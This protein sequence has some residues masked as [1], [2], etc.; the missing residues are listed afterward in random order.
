MSNG[1][2]KRGDLSSFWDVFLKVYDLCKE[3][4]KIFWLIIAFILSFLASS[5]EAISLGLIIPLLNSVI[6][7]SRNAELGILNDLVNMFSIGETNNL[8]IVVALMI[9][10]AVILKN[11]FTYIAEWVKSHIVSKVNLS[12][13][14]KLMNKF[15][16]RDTLFFEK[17]SIGDLNFTLGLSSSFGNI[18]SGFH[19][20]L[21]N[22]FFC[23]SYAAVMVFISP[24]ITVFIILTF[25]PS[26]Y[27]LKLLSKIIKKLSQK[28]IKLNSKISRYT[29][30]ILSSIRLIKLYNTEEKED[31]KFKDLNEK[32]RKLNFT[33]GLK[34]SLAGKIQEPL[35]VAS[36]ILLAGISFFFFLDNTK[37]GIAG[38]MAF[39]VILKRFEFPAQ[40]LIKE[41]TMLPTKTPSLEKL[42]S[43]FKEEPWM[44]IK[45]GNKEFK[46][47][48]K[49][50]QFKNVSFKYI[51]D[52]ETV[53]KNINLKI[54]K[55][56]MT[57]LVGSTGAGKST[58]ANLIPRI[59]DCKK[60]KIIIDGINVR[61]Y[62]INSLRK[63]IAFVSQDSEI[64]NTTIRDNIC[65]GIERKVTNKELKSVIKKTALEDFVK[66]LP[67]KLNT[68][69]GE[70]GIDVS[71][72][73]KQRISIA[74][75]LIKDPD[76][77]ILDEATSA[78]DT[79]TERK[80]QR[81]IEHALKGRTV[82][83]I[84]HRLST[85]EKA[86]KIVVIEKGKI[87]E[88]GSFK[89][90]LKKKRMFYHYW[91]IQTKL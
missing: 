89:Q 71:G 78:L 9:L 23:I 21:Q 55:G 42:I 43:G 3:Q 46:N 66:K 47:L 58:I 41:I 82:L 19:G 81:S 4:V 72:G 12:L 51:K 27:F 76:I 34:R 87:I 49:E 6:D 44:I 85:I 18:I 90:L 48:K 14:T 86:D 73:E 77:L 20:I 24:K 57:A 32:S 62:D 50:I 7:P 39:F 54:K 26:Y 80:I 68:I 5:L 56:E 31:E 17:S 25:L 69:L 8:I 16:K 37:G 83:A 15:L 1:K 59:F 88:Q 28:S 33:I 64:L 79:V 2:I 10:L 40:D 29:F 13:K 35:L 70:R 30:E 36:V 61:D 22:L 63:N 67:K 60:G 91:N 45:S 74:R 53:L 84:A 75:A 11:F 38:F 52:Q 65:Y